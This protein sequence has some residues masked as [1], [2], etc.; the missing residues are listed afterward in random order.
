MSIFH[1]FAMLCAI[2]MVGRDDDQLAKRLTEAETRRLAAEVQGQLQFQLQLQLVIEE[3]RPTAEQQV[4]EM[5]RARIAEAKMRSTV[6][7]VG[8]SVIGDSFRSSQRR[9]SRP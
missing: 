9:A 4:Q 5:R 6:E 7:I 1:S 8:G 2:G 3:M